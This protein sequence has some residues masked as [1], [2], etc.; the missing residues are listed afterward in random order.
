MFRLGILIISNLFWVACSEDAAGNVQTENVVRAKVVDGAGLPVS[1]AKVSLRPASYLPEDVLEGE[2]SGVLQAEANAQGVVEIAI[3][4]SNSFFLEAVKDTSL[5]YWQDSITLNEDLY[6][7]LG[8]LTLSE[9]AKLTI[10]WQAPINDTLVWYVGVEGT[11]IWEEIE[12]ENDQVTLSHLG[13]GSYKL[14]FILM[15]IT[16]TGKVKNIVGTLNEEEFI[17]G[18]EKN[19]KLLQSELPGEQAVQDSLKHAFYEKCKKTADESRCIEKK[20]DFAECIGSAPTQKDIDTCEEDKI[21]EA[22]KGI[23]T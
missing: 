20:T 4:D 9:P 5:K 3:M 14:D 13:A 21:E 19:V 7:D 16:P 18:E 6:A 11:N 23:S 22:Q 15:S 1:G 12:V 2:N 17:P 8:T 10:D